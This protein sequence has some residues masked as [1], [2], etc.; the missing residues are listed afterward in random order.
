MCGYFSIVFNDFTFEGISLTDF[1][2]FSPK[3]LR[4]MIK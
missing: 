1:N 2:F 3:N 4:K